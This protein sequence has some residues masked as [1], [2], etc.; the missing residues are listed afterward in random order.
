MAVLIC[1]RTKS[2]PHQCS[3]SFFFAVKQ[4]QEAELPAELP[5]TTLLQTHKR[6]ITF[7]GNSFDLPFLKKRYEI[8]HIKQPFSDTQSVD[9]Y[10]EACHLREP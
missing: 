3:S 8:N 10:R 7:N 9:L 5:L 6:I 4:E 1:L 2:E